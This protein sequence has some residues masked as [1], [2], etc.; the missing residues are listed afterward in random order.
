MSPNKVTKFVDWA[1]KQPTMATVSLFF[2]IYVLEAEGEI[3]V[4]LGQFIIL[5]IC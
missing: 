5:L 1:C 2:D 3:Q 4:L